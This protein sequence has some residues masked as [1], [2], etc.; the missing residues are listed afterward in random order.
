MTPHHRRPAPARHEPG[1]AGA[2]GPIENDTAVL[3][4]LDPETLREMDRAAASGRNLN[5]RNAG[6]AAGD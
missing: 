1:A 3:R 4:R 6:D 5:G 2:S